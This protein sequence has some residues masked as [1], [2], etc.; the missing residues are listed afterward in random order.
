MVIT[1]EFVFFY[2]TSEVFSNWHPSKFKHRGVTFANS[3]QAMMY[4]KAELMQDTAIMA[5]TRRISDP[6]KVKQI[7]RKVKPWNQSLWDSK[8]LDIS[9]DIQFL[10]FQLMPN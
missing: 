6:Y 8:K 9:H 1:D 4:C 2:G 7:G 5:E 3:E 10:S